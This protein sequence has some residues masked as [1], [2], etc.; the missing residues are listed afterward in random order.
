MIQC[1]QFR[2]TSFHLEPEWS[3]GPWDHCEKDDLQRLYDCGFEIGALQN[4]MDEAGLQKGELGHDGARKYLEDLYNCQVRLDSWFQDF[5]SVSPSPLYQ[6]IQKSSKFRTQRPETELSEPDD[7]SMPEHFAFPSLRTA[8]ST[9]SYWGLKI[10]VAGTVRQLRNEI[11][12]SP[13]KSAAISL[14]QSGPDHSHQSQ[15]HGK[16]TPQGALTREKPP[17]LDHHGSLPS[18]TFPSSKSPVSDSP[19]TMAHLTND[20]II[21]ATNILRSMPFCLSDEQGLLGS[22]QALFPLRVALFILRLHPGT[23]LQWCQKFY[24][25]LNEQKGLRYAREIAKVDGGH[26]TRG[27]ERAAAVT[28]SVTPPPRSGSQPYTVGGSNQ[29]C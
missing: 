27:N 28:P 24:R 9:I 12:E 5:L 26:G 25:S 17:S 22:Q 13:P 18:R 11:A 6:V 21:L 4:Q 1:V 20:P 16:Q 3:R 23:E 7:E 15:Y 29:S 19:T 2:Q 10:V 8:T 14:A